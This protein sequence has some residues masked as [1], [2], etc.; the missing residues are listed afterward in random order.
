[1]RVLV[2]GVLLA[3]CV[4]AAAFA[5][6]NGYKNTG[7][8]LDGI[9]KSYM[10]RPIAAVMSYHGASWLERPEREQEEGTDK[11]IKMLNLKPTDVVADIGAGSGYFTFRIAPL[12]PQG[13]V[14]ATDIQVEMLDIIKGRKAKG[15]GPNVI[16][17][18]SGIAD[19]KLPPSSID[20]IIMVDVYHEFSAPRE[21]GIA[22]RRAL[23]PGGRIALVEYRAEDPNVPI[24][25]VHKMSEAQAKKEMAVLGLEWVST[26]SK[27]L[28]WQHLMIFAK[29]QLIKQ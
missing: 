15:E 23:K 27:T 19:P 6:D 1:M 7:L 22:M 9:G 5:A 25:E 18:H 10:D 26:D 13:K 11:L 21:M 16:P 14:Y 29:P 24:R 2:R 28:P 3:V 12:V 17:V 4:S 8:T 20:L